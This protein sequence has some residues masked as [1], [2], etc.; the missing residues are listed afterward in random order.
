MPVGEIIRNSLTFI[1]QFLIIALVTLIG[2]L[3]GLAYAYGHGVITLI[4]ATI[5]AACVWVLV[6][7]EGAMFTR[8]GAFGN[9]LGV[10]WIV[11]F[12][13]AAGALMGRDGEYTMGAVFALIQCGIIFWIMS[14][15]D[16][17]HELKHG[18]GK[19]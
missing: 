17:A 18:V 13:I 3:A 5:Q 19:E 6:T 4:L 11:S 10:G 2:V 9:L 14:E 1:S 12:G 8:W 16:R 15:S 7:D